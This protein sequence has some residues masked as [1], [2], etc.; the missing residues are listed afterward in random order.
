VKTASTGASRHRLITTMCASHAAGESKSTAASSIAVTTCA[1]G[2]SSR[3]H[4]ARRLVID[5]DEHSSLDRT[6]SVRLAR[7]VPLTQRRM[8]DYGTVHPAGC[9][10][11]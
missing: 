1:V 2:C 6:T 5:C 3:S 10:T 7:V 11:A 8:I 9:R 4:A